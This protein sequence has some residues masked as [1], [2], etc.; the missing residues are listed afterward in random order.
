MACRLGDIDSV[1]I[2]LKA[3]AQIDSPDSGDETPLFAAVR[4][5]HIDMIRYLLAQGAQVNARRRSNSETALFEAVRNRSFDI[6]SVLIQNGADI[7]LASASGD[8]PLMV[9]SMSNDSEMVQFLGSNGAVFH[10]PNQELLFAAS[11]GNVEA[12]RRALAA[13]A[14]P[15][16]SH[17]YGITPLM[18][19]A[20]NGQTAAVKALIAA[21]ASINAFD[22]SHNTP[23]MYAIEGRRTD[24]V[25]ALLDAGA[26]PE[27]K[28]LG[29]VT[30][31]DQAA[32]YL[33]DPEIVH[34]LIA[35]GLPVGAGD[36][37]SVTPL[38]NA[39]SFGHIKTVKI[40]LD[41]HVPVNLQSREGL[42]ALTHAA[43]AGNAAIVSLLLEAGADPTIRDN[44][45]RD[46]LDYAIE[47][48]ADEQ[49]LITLLRNLPV[50]PA[51]PAHASQ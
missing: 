27:L 18:A 21:G 13:G 34:R 30:A 6:L 29:Q 35:H 20:Q 12:L 22:A 38:M 15:N 49:N 11:H 43:M 17:E 50:Q 31:L 33:D 28:N 26:N 24:T 45:G 14:T 36:T 39:A 37:I 10:S 7:N 3:G 32:I 9:A 2:L 44:K 1:R 48:H 23:L 51:A 40:L 25:L 46:A 47:L 42:T 8:T 16:Q 19:A 4:W 41:A 5:R